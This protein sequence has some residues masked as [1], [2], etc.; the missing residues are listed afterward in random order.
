MIWLMRLLRRRIGAHVI[1]ARRNYS[2]LVPVMRDMHRFCIAMAG[3][4][5]NVDDKGCIA[6]DPMVWSSGGRPKRRRVVETVGDF[7]MLPGPQ[8]LWVGDWFKWPDIFISAR[9][10]GR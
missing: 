4:I 5:V 10:V 2:G 6:P 1:D 8:R 7:A 9:E 3:A